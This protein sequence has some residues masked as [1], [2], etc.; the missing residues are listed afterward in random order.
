MTK[1]LD[2]RKYRLIE[3][4]IKMDDE[5]A[6][7]RIEDQIESIQ[8]GDDIWH[9]V[10]RPM[11]KTITL[12]EMEKEQNYT[13]IDEKTFFD[14]AEKIGIEESIEELLAMLD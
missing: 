4:I 10:F 6:I 8:K 7:S 11:R 1:N 2:N 5:A 12:A 13:P 9:A 14:L 3:E